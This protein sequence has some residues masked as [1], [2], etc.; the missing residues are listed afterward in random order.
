MRASA[1]EAVRGG[2]TIAKHLAVPLAQLLG[3][4]RR[5]ASVSHVPAPC[6]RAVR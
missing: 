5:Y 6:S 3:E 4:P 2:A 1:V